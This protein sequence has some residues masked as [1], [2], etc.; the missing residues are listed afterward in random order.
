MEKSKD[1]LHFYNE[2]ASDSMEVHALFSVEAYLVMI[3]LP[4]SSTVFREE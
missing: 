2:M 1:S 4:I 3:F